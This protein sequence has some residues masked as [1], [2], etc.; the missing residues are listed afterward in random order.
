MNQ[1]EEKKRSPFVRL[2]EA[3]AEEAL[4]MLDALAGKDLRPNG[5]EVVWLIRQEWARRN[6]TV[7]VDQP[8]PAPAS[9]QQ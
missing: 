4:A 1:T 8:Q 5:A 2:P 6:P 9:A 3:E 7:L